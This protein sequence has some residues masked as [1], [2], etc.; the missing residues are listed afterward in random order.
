VPPRSGGND[1]YFTL[2]VPV[3]VSWGAVGLGS[4]V[5]ARS[6]VLLIYLD[7][8]GDNVT[9]S[10]RHGEGHWEPKWLDEVSVEVL[11]GTGIVEQNGR[12][13]MMFRARCDEGCRSW[14]NGF[15]DVTSHEVEATYAFGPSDVVLMSD[16]A[17]APLLMHVEVG[18]FTIDMKRTEGASDAPLVDNEAS[19]DGVDPEDAARRTGMRDGGAIAHAVLML[20]GTSF[21]LPLGVALLFW[22]GFAAHAVAQIA[23][24]VFVLAGFGVGVSMSHRYQRVRRVCCP[25]CVSQ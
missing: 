1:I 17:A 23:A 3:G 7:A 19:N 4:T 10:P 16:D 25:P 22:G 14:H 24:V 6:L 5:M 12:D 21:L 8:A 13:Y 2:R 15:L 9:F 11:D 20:V 18:Q